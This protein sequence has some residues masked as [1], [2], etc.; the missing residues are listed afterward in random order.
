MCN[1]KKIGQYVWD[2]ER[3]KGTI[4]YW[5]Y[6]GVCLI[7]ICKHDFSITFVS[8]YTINIDKLGGLSPSLPPAFQITNIHY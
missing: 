8:Q 5:F 3:T 2:S 7:F 6:N 1:M 4:L